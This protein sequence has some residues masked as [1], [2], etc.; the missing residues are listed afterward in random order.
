MLSEY[1]LSNLN[2]PAKKLGQ[3]SAQREGVN[4]CMFVEK[5][6]SVMNIFATVV[7]T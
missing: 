6:L 3:F 2:Y 4:I 7:V 5:Y 1:S